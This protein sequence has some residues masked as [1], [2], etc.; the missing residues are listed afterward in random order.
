MDGQGWFLAIHCFTRYVKVTFFR[1]AALKPVPT[2]ESKQKDV[3]YLDIRED[4]ALDE[5][6][7][8]D[9]VKQAS[10]LPGRKM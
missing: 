4:D 1:G 2:G 8:A 7:F 6:R 9:W 3:R 5:A 10:R